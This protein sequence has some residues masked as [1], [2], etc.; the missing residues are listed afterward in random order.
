M[1]VAFLKKPFNHSTERSL[2]MKPLNHILADIAAT[3][4]NTPTSQTHQSDRL[5][6]RE[7]SVWAVRAALEAAYDAGINDA[8][9]KLS[10]LSS[11]C[12]M[13]VDRWN[14]GDLAEA[15]RACSDAI[16]SIGKPINAAANARSDL[17]TPFDGYE[18]HG[19]FEIADDG[20]RFCEQV[21]DDEAQFWSV[22]GH[23]PGQG[24]ECLGNF[25]S[26][27]FAEEVYARITGESYR[28]R[29]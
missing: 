16:S 21:P 4:L 17:P 24:V 8:D 26:R 15:I 28:D 7:V 13:V 20:R 9:S 19:I 10:R 3:H 11:A 12:Q 5:D 27:E 18:I 29:L 6:I 2:T 22:Y 25:K 14:K 1:F 23:I